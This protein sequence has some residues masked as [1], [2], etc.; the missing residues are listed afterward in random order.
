MRQTDVEVNFIKASE[1]KEPEELQ[2]NDNFTWMFSWLEKLIPSLFMSSM[3]DSPCA[4]DKY[5][6]NECG[7]SMRAASLVQDYRCVIALSH[8]LSGNDFERNY[9]EEKNSGMVISASGDDIQQKLGTPFNFTEDTD[10]LVRNILL[11]EK[12]LQSKVDSISS[13]FKSFKAYKMASLVQNYSSICALN[14]F[15]GTSH[16]YAAMDLTADLAEVEEEKMVNHGCMQLGGKGTLDP[17]YVVVRGRP[18]SVRKSANH[19]VTEAC[20]SGMDGSLEYC[21]TTPSSRCN[22]LLED[23]RDDV[24]DYVISSDKG[25]RA[26]WVKNKQKC[27]CLPPNLESSTIFIG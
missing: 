10:Q 25:V 5:R 3:N 6:D 14:N 7:K 18:L 4:I 22:T 20:I 24:E 16:P 26:N 2:P 13:D 17:L 15:Y 9:L 19:E 11:S 12:Q 8:F 21:E 1:D 27:D 23:F